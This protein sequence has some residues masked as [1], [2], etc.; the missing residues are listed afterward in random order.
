MSASMSG[1]WRRR[2]RTSAAIIGDSNSLRK[3][4]VLQLE[5]DDVLDP[6]PVQFDLHRQHLRLDVAEFVVQHGRLV[7]DSPTAP[8]RLDARGITL[9]L[10]RGIVPAVFAAGSAG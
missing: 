6:I 9:E 4:D 1:S 10:E 3:R 5:R 7:D 2:A 8:T